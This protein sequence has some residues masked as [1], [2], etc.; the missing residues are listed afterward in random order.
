MARW[1]T[2]RLGYNERNK[3]YGILVSDL[4][5]IDGL[6]CGQS[7]EVKMNGEWIET[8]MEM[9]CGGIWYLVGID[10]DELECLE[11]RVRL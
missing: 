9:K 8:R 6:H 11:V 4:W 2:G 10:C 1:K 5:E 7:L 3:R